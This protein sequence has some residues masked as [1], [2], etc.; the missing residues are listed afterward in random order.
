MSDREMLADRAAFAT[1]A[2]GVWD[3]MREKDSRRA[4]AQTEAGDRIVE[5]WSQQGRAIELLLPL[6]TDPSTE[7]RFA[8]AAHLLNLGAA[9]AAVRV[10]EELASNPKGL[11]APAAG[12]LLRQWKLSISLN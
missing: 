8:A 11:V 6:L 5:H 9:N 10:L 7:V 12:L 4:N 3:T 1:T 2:R